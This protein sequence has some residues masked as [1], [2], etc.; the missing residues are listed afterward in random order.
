MKKIVS[1]FPIM[2]SWWCHNNQNCCHDSFL[3]FCQVWHLMELSFLVKPENR[4]LKC[5]VELINWSLNM[6]YEKLKN[7]VMTSSFISNLPYFSCNM[8]LVCVNRFELRQ[9]TK[10]MKDNERFLLLEDLFYYHM[11]NYVFKWPSP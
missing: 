9:G 1:N 3:Y 5:W 10:K 4:T 6:T 7:I 8:C 11:D 2:M